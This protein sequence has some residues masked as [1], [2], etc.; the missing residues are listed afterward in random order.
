MAALDSPFGRSSMCP[1]NGRSPATAIRAVEGVSCARLL[2]RDLGLPQQ[3]EIDVIRR[4]GVV[5]RRLDFIAWPRR[6]HEV[7]RDNDGK[8][9]FV[10]LIGLAGEQRTQ[11]G[12]LPSQG[13]CSI[14]FLLSVCSKPPI[15]KLWPSRNSTVVEARRTISAGT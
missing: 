4:Q 12:T 13:S 11:H 8:V 2:P 7:R 14:A 3:E 6:A 15:T 9:C 5:G 10:L 1:V